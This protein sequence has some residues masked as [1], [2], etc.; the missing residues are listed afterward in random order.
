MTESL[1]ITY[2]HL[3]KNVP[4]TYYACLSGE[5]IVTEEDPRSLQEGVILDDGYEN[6][7]W[8]TGILK[9]A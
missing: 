1:H 4:K 7:A 8:A 5:G 2:C 3:K 6:K 9:S